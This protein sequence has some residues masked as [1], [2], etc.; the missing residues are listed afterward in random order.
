ML[1]LD[2][3]D[4]KTVNDSLGHGVRDA[5]LRVV[6]ER[7][8]DNL[9]GADTAARLG[10]DEFAVLLEGVADAPRPRTPR[11]RAP[12]LEPPFTVE[13][14]SCPSGAASGSRSRPAAARRWTT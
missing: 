2:L 11:A 1:F 4:F 9:R 6:G 3:D 12:A 7:L 5:L 8:R 14:P 10:G 13:A